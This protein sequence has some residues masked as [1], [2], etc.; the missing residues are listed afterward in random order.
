MT[1][2]PTKYRAKAGSAQHPIL[3]TYYGLLAEFGCAEIPLTQV[4]PKYF[5]MEPAKAKQKA[6]LQQLPVPVYRAGSQK[7]PWLISAHVL[8]NYLDD[9]KSK[10]INTFEFINS[11]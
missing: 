5:G 3:S 2:A 10:S 8:A 11:S 9:L 4:A 1:E 7:S 6:A